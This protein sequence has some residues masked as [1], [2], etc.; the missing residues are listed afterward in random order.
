MG[1][2]RGHTP[3]CRHQA[4]GS[5]MTIIR[6]ETKKELRT[7]V[8]GTDLCNCLNKPHMPVILVLSLLGSHGTVQAQCTEC[9]LT[10]NHKTALKSLQLL[11]AVLPLQRKFIQPEKDTLMLVLKNVAHYVYWASVIDHTSSH[12]CKIINHLR[13][14]LTRHSKSPRR[15]TSKG[16]KEN[17]YDVPWQGFGSAV[18]WHFGCYSDGK[19]YIMCRCCSLRQATYE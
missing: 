19:Y 4:H 17:K 7:T 12:C 3:T 18:L 11:V 15:E 2:T 14:N 13:K 5:D 9:S 1:L 8:Q 6:N 16:S 10:Q